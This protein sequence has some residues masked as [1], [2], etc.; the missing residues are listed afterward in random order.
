M[1]TLPKTRIEAKESGSIHYYT[2][3]PCNRGHISP[4]FTSIGKCMA[5]A[6]EDTMK[7]YVYTTARRRAYDNHEGFVLAAMK[8]H[9]GYYEYPDTGYINAHTPMEITCRKHG[10]FMM[11]PTNHMQGKGCKACGI[12]NRV[13]KQI[14]SVDMFIEEATK[15]WEGKFDYSRVE[16]KGAKSPVKLICKE[17]LEVSISQTPTNHLSKLEPCTKCN[18][19]KSAPEREVAEFLAQYTVVEQH[20]RSI[21]KPKE[22]DIWLPEFAIGIEY[23]GLYA[24]RTESVG[25]LHREKY[26]LAKKAGIRLVQIFDDEW[27]NKKE[28]VKNRLLAFIGKSEVYNARSLVLKRILM[29]EAR[30]FLV[31]THIQGAGVSS[32]NYGLYEDDKLVAVAT[33]GKSRSGAM[34]GAMVEG[35]WEVSRYASIGRVRGG[36][37]KM[38]K[39]FIADEQP[40]RIISYCDLRYGTGGL[41]K[42]VGFIL[43]SITEP[44]YWWVP[45]GRI[46]RVPRYTVQKHKVAKPEHVLHKYYSPN[47]TENEICAEAGWLKIKGV[48]SQKWVLDLQNPQK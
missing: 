18:H 12:I 23:H 26:E 20:N 30:P 43:H 15:I 19:M 42:A 27:A 13:A 14:K 29:S 31:A 22:I 9:G 40:R 1:S 39:Q 25:N 35:E 17:H 46:E 47:K 45:K 5:C 2:G 41:Y 11:S 34:L 7:A 6:R 4:R 32:R 44:D 16:Y 10:V 37:S 21:I 36:F 24:H 3:V 28:L 48:G 38:L 8:I 33:F